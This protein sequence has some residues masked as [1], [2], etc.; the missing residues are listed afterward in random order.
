M[1][2][3]HITG[4]FDFVN[5]MR[6]HK[7]FV[8]F[9]DGRENGMTIKDM[10]H[11]DRKRMIASFR[12]K[13]YITDCDEIDDDEPL[14]ANEIMLSN[15]DKINQLQEEIKRLHNENLHI[16]DAPL[17]KKKV[18]V[19]KKP[20]KIIQKSYFFP[21]KEVEEDVEEDVNN[22]IDFTDQHIDPLSLTDIM[23]ADLFEAFPQSK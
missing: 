2:L 7:Q 18:V 6:T 23:D 17:S 5:T 11:F 4:I 3:K 20:K 10:I 9:K 16:I 22:G 15:I 14:T 19:E 13:G 21:T 8:T 1:N 12:S